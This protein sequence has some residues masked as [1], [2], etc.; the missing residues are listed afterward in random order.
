MAS[1]YTNEDITVLDDLEHMRLRRGMYIGEAD[2]PKQLISEIIDNALDEVQEGYSDE[3]IVTVNTKDNIY[4]V[5]DFGR[6]IPHGKKKLDDGT[7]KEIIEVL[8]TKAHSGGK[9]NTENYSTSAGLNGL[10]LTITNALSNFIEHPFVFRGF[11]INSME[12]LI[13]GLTYK[14]P[15]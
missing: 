3:L 12:G 13:A 5:R 10:G 15:I 4:T 2:N 9:F 6:G 7:E 8:L 1:K 11:S 14:D